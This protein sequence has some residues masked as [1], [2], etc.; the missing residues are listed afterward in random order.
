[1]RFGEAGQAIDAGDEDVAE[2]T[3]LQVGQA[4]Q[5]ELRPFGLAEP[6]PQQF[7]VPS[8]FTPKATYIVCCETRP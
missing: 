1:M 4:G 3:I 6:Q 8:K 7:L 2:P 5:P